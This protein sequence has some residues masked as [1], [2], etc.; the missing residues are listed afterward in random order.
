MS[1]QKLNNAILFSP[2]TV[3]LDFLSHV[4]SKYLDTRIRSIQT[5]NQ[6]L[7]DFY[8]WL[9]QQIFEKQEQFLW[10]D[11]IVEQLSKDLKNSFPEKAGFSP[12][13]LWRMRRFYIEYNGL[14]IL[15]Q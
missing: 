11:G 5:V 8:W 13:N 1:E 6:N 4:K 2:D 10:G 12:Q 14:P 3:Y 7:I 15:S 9:G